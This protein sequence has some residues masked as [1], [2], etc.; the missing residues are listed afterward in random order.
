VHGLSGSDTGASAAASGVKHGGGG[1][2]LP[3]YSTVGVV[4]N[5]ELADGGRAWNA[6]YIPQQ[7]ILAA[8]WAVGVTIHV[9]AINGG[10]P[11]ALRRTY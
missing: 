7:L 11:R 4:L 1:G 9:A 2:D 5:A 8:R 3:P 10:Q 6:V